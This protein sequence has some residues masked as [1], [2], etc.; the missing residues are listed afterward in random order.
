M[1]PKGTATLHR[2]RTDFEFYA[3]NTLKIRSKSGAIS[4]LV[5]NEAQQYIHKQL[6][7]QL[8]E[9]GQIRALILKGRQQG[10]STYVE[11]RYYWKVTHRRGVQAY[12]LTHEAEA[13]KNLFAMAKRYHENYPEELRRHT[14]ASNAKELLFDL[15]DSGYK[16]GTAGNEGAGRSNTAQ[17]FHGSEVAYWDHAES[18]MAGAI[19]AVP[20]AP[21]TEIILESTSAGATGLFYSMCQSALKGEGKYRLIFV[22][23]FWQSEYRST[24]TPDFTSTAEETDYAKTYGLDDSQ[25]QWRR[26]KISELFGISNFRREYPATPEEA[27][28]ADAEGALWSREL[29]EHN[30]VTMP[31]C[32]MTRIV[33]AIDPAVTSNAASDETG[34]V[35]AGLGT[36]EH[37]YILEDISGKYSPA[38]WA[39]KAVQAYYKWDANQI[40]GE[41]NQGGDLIE[42]NIKTV[43][44]TIPYRSVHASRGKRVRAEPVSALDAQNKIHHV[45]YHTRLEDQMVTWDPAASTVSPDRID[46]RVWAIWA[47]MID[48]SKPPRVRILGLP[49]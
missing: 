28:L 49:R 1:T 6:E 38:E 19:Q 32:D 31:N 48:Q 39:S 43:D 27:F 11:A 47:L 15:L 24:T 26:D 18:H 22:P 8:A 46:A 44:D 34:I 25:L 4:P 29:I 23:W 12:I 30:R 16:V 45:G 20:D 21:G 40:I 35:V 33:V 13:S 17:Y 42:V 37:G 14:A 36:D 3:R 2:L 41:V 9:T 5:L 7:Q 10:C